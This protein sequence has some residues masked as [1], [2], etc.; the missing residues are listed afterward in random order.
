MRALPTSF[1]SVTHLK[2]TVGNRPVPKSAVTRYPP[3]CAPLGAQRWVTVTRWV[4]LPTLSYRETGGKHSNRY[5][6][7][8]EARDRRG[9]SSEHW[10]SL[11]LGSERN[12]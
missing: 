12:P 2:M 11:F 6:S 9:N 8:L 3:S 1:R 4:V 7:A 10:Q 5:S